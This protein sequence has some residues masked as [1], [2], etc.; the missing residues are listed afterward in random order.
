VD[1]AS[2]NVEALILDRLAD[3][4]LPG[5]VADL[6][7]AALLGDTDLDAA[8]NV[9]GYQ[10]PGVQP[11]TAANGTLA[12]M[13]LQSVTVVG[14]RGIGATATLCLSPGPGL[15]L[16]VGRNGSGKSSFAEATELAVTGVSRRWSKNTAARTGWR[17]LHTA[18]TSRITVKLA[19]DGQAGT[20]TVAQEWPPETLLEDATAYVQEPGGPRQYGGAVQ[21][22]GPLE[23]YRPFLS[24]SELGTLVDGKPSEMYDALQ[25]ILGLGQLIDAERRL[26]AARKRFDDASKTARQ[27]LPGLLTR[28]SQHPDDRARRAEA[29]LTG[30]WDLAAVEALAVGEQ[31][32]DTGVAGR[33]QQVAAIELPTAETMTAAAARLNAAEQ[34]IT[35]QTGT[36]T[37]EA[38]QIKRLRTTIKKR[39]EKR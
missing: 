10:R 31:Q 38:Q 27:E 37:A 35:A 36:P 24:Y 20:T 6:V 14:F 29:A 1:A 32:P 39:N 33:L 11:D 16:V 2:V 23:L 25:A 5:A 7:V 17:N 15:T 26:T 13:F 34:K 22:A 18:G 19:T 21:W 30:R 8:L 3:A 12:G 4:D 9:D 28:L